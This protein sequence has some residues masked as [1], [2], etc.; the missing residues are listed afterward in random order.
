MLDKLINPW[1]LM[2]GKGGGGGG[3]LLGGVNPLTGL[4]G[5]NVPG[6]EEAGDADEQSADKED[7]AINKWGRDKG[8]GED[9]GGWS[10][11]IG[12]K[13]GQAHGY[14]E[15]KND[16]GKGYAEDRWKPE[17]GGGY[18]AENADKGKGY[19]EDRWKPEMG[20]GHSKGNISKGQGYWKD[21]ENKGVNGTETSQNEWNSKANNMISEGKKVTG[22]PKKLGSEWSSWKKRINGGLV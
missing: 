18:S 14:D 16:K 6:D 19:A 12:K 10:P 5:G 4:M 17:F 1:M 22:K 3:G 7:E 20:G 13:F 9:D 21:R 8:E 2:G 11:D 15:D